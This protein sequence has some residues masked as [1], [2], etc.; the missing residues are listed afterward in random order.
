[1]RPTLGEN[2]ET[3]SVP[4]TGNLVPAIVQ[5]IRRDHRNMEQLLGILEQELAIFRRGERP[6]FDI[7]SGIV[8]YFRFHPDSCHRPKEALVLAALKEQAPDRTL[9]LLEGETED[10]QAQASLEIF[11]GLIED[12]INE[13][14]V[15]REVVVAAAKDFAAHVKRL[16]RFAE[17]ELLPAALQS[18]TSQA[19]AALDEKLADRNNPIVDSVLE[20]RFAE[21]AERLG[22][23]EREDQAERAR[24]S[25]GR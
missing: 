3:P 1:M 16:I 23:W 13:Q 25:Q 12:V 5:S 4:K 7:L 21:L 19:W 18:L 22:K 24:F 9:A 15:S 8:E 10:R 20:A 17:G 2:R 14:E 6:D 11:T